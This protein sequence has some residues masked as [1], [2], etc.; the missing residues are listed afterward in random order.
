MGNTKEPLCVAI[1]FETAGYYGHSICAIGMTKISGSRVLE[2]YYSL[3][4]PPSSRVCFTEIHGLR[5]S[6]LKDE[7]SFPEVWPEALEFIGRAQYL[8]AHNARFDRGVLDKTCIYFEQK[9][10]QIPFLCTLKGS[11]KAI[12]L[13]SHSL[14]YL[15]EYFDI[16]LD[17][18]HAG[19][20]ARACALIYAR[21]KDLGV[22]EAEMMLGF[23]K[24]R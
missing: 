12:K 15:C 7:R 6:D 8:V 19:S 24:R 2:Q 16:E 3:V 11:R 1:D 23:S 14:G 21:L 17:H 4:R 13:P 10:P 5:W 9:F 22:G 20:D 18:H